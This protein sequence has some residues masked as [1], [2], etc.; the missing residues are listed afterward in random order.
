MTKLYCIISG[1]R[2][3]GL[4]AGCVTAGSEARNQSSDS[5]FFSSDQLTQLVVLRLFY[6][7]GK[8]KWYH[9]IGM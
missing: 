5:V 1:A 6:Y 8:T 9:V 3:L 7:R 4:T 2:C